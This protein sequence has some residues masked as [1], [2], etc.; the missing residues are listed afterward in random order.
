M[1]RFWVFVIICVVALGMGF[2]VVRFMTREEI[3]YVNQASYEVNSGE[4]I[5]LDIV[6]KNLKSG[7]KIYLDVQN[8]N[9]ISQTEDGEYNFK[10]LNGGST[11]IV[12][13]SNLKSFMPVS[14]QVTVGDGNRATP[15]LIRNQQ[16][17]EEIGT[18]KNADD[19]ESLKYPLSSCY[20]LTADISLSGDWTPIGNGSEDGFTGNFDFN[21]HSISNINVNKNVESA[22]LFAKIGTNGYVK[23]AKLDSVVISS[24]TLKAG[25]VAGEN[26]G[27]IE[28]ARVTNATITNGSNSAYVGGL[29]GFNSGLITKSQIFSST[30]IST[31]TD[32]YVGGLV[33]ASN[34]ISIK[35]N[36]LITRSSAECSLNTENAKAVG[37]LVGAI[38]GSSIENCYTGNINSQCVVTSSQDSWVGGIVGI[39]KYTNLD[40]RTIR[41]NVADTYSVMQ[42]V[43]PNINKCGEIIG[44]NEFDTVDSENYNRIYGCYYMQ[45]DNVD[46]ST[47]SLRG[48]A[49]Y[50]ENP[51]DT[52]TE[53][54]PGTYPKTLADLKIQQT[55]K[56]FKN[57]D[58][59]FDEEGVWVMPSNDL[60]KLSFIV[61]YVSSRISYYVSPNELTSENFV[62]VLKNADPFTTY[63]ITRDITLSEDYLP[64][65]FNG[66]LTCNKLDENGKPTVGIHLA[67]KKE[68][69]VNE[70]AIAV[71]K[72]LGSSAYITNV[73]VDITISNVS[74]SDHVAALAAYNEGVVE[75][76]YATNKITTDY[77]GST[78]Y[79]GG[80]IAEN[81]GKI[82]NCK[83]DVS[84]TY[85]LSPMNLYVGGIAGWSSNSITKCTNLGIIE[86][87]GRAGEK[88]EDRQAGVG[89]VGG[90]CGATKAEVSNCIN[91]GQIIGQTEASVT[92]YAG[93]V[94]YI[95]ND[96]DAVV[97][98]CVNNAQITGSNV[99]GIAGVSLGAIE[100]CSVSKVLLNGK[101]IGGL[102]YNIK[103][104]YMKNSM[105]NGTA[106]D[107]TKVGCGAVYMIDVT[108][109]HSAYCQYI[110]SS[111][112]FMGSGD[113]YYESASNI[114]GDTPSILSSTS[115]IDDHA[116][117]NCIHVKRDGDK[118]KRSRFDSGIIHWSIGNHGNED[119]EISDAQATG[120]EGMYNVFR[121]NGYNSTYWLYN[122]ETV[123]SYI[124]LKNLP[125]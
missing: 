57:Y 118:I 23:D 55:Y 89:Y 100:Y 93:I 116:F 13:T 10:A 85:S 84:I 123:G 3:I 124:Q 51:S 87:T 32:S 39:C 21:A 113:N 33:G 76:C 115:A 92:V 17:L 108:E 106:I 86:V 52:G 95:S 15:F 7:T 53:E 14:V 31:G 71:F 8:P 96:A 60:P 98:Y 61:N 64:F 78:L 77:N 59:Q 63:R 90:I 1:K 121:D 70:G 114:R 107:A 83:S 117:D 88:R 27:T 69:N 2:T 40:S 101:Y 75:N 22:G 6:K 48:V 119:I 103:K 105:T 50:I 104:G 16:Q 44:S 58:W 26:N 72:T 28:T 34:L 94:G 73:L 80:L 74:T 65:D 47:I 81:R 109:N 62:D 110:F 67:L 43:D 24:Q 20:K 122:T 46:S 37:G 11:S 30:V 42:F 79:I 38:E 112:D 54:K 41:A 12:I 56:S 97:S 49:S 68:A 45:R 4:N 35:Y 111:C 25:S 66:R 82:I 120:A 102:A 125:K 5:V 19:G 29:V 99:G 18:A 36:T 91:K 9:I